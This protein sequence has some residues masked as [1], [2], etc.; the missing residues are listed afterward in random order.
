MTV[1]DNPAR[2]VIVTELVGQKHLRNA[3]SINSGVFQLGGMIGPAVSGAL[4]AASAA[5]SP[6]R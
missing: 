3:I 6:S 5:A 4:L 2:Q 1:I